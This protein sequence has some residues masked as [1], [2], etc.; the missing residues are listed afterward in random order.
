[1]LG[2]FDIG[3]TGLIAQSVRLNLVASN[4]ANAETVVSAD[5]RAYRARQAVFQVSKPTDSAGVGV[6]V[7]RIVES[8][9]PARLEYRPNHPLANEAGYVAMPN[10]NVAEQTVDMISAS[11]AYQTNIEVMNISRQLLLKTL[12]LGK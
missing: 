5:G 3:T 8:D 6:S 7:S 2:S 4:L 1:M 9:A 12:D 11:R 10:V